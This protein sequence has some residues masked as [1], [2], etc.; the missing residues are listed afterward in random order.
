MKRALVAGA[1]AAGAAFAQA[2]PQAA[3][4]PAAAASAAA[5]AAPTESPTTITITGERLNEPRPAG[6][7]ETVIQ[8]EEIARR[9]A[10]NV[11]DVLKDVPGVGV[12]GGP[13][14]SGMKFTLRG[15]SDNEDVLFKIDGAAKGFE[16]YR[17]GG[18][19]LLEP[20]LLNAL[21]VERGPSVLSGSGALGGTIEATTK[22]AANLLRPGE[23][24]G[25]LVK[26]GGNDN[27]SELL[28]MGA[29]Y[30]RPGDFDLLAAVIRRKS[31]NIQLADGSYLP[32]SETDSRSLLAKVGWM[33]HDRFI[34]ELGYVAYETAPQRQPYD[35]TG[36]LPGVGGVVRR[37]LDDATTTLRFNWD[38]PYGFRLRGLLSRERTYLHDIHLYHDE[39]GNPE[40]TIC[41]TS[42]VIERC[43]DDWH[44]DN[45][46]AELFADTRFALGP[47]AADLTAGLQRTDKRR[48]TQRVTSNELV[49]DNNY[50]GGFNPTQ[51]PGDHVSDALVAEARLRWRDF[52][53]VPGIRFDRYSVSS[54]GLAREHMEA[55][56]QNPDIGF[57]KNQPSIGL[58][59]QPGQGA[60]AFTARYNEGFRPPL[61]DEYF[62]DG[63]DAAEIPI[64]RCRRTTGNPLRPGNIVN[65][66]TIQ[67]LYDRAGL[68][69]PYD[70]ALDHAPTSEICG[71]LYRPQ[72]SASRELILA[73]RPPAVDG[74]AWSARLTLY[75]ILT[76]HL[77]STLQWV[78]GEVGQPGEE[79]RRGIE[80]E[81]DYRSR[82]LFAALS[83][84]RVR[85]SIENAGSAT[86]LSLDVPA[87]TTVLTLGGNVPQWQANAG[88][89]VR[90]IDDRRTWTGSDTPSQCIGPIAADGS[91]EQHGV[92]VHELFAAWQINAS[93]LLRASVD[94][95]T[96]R[97]YCGVSSF[98]GAVGFRA[99]GRAAKVSVTAQF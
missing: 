85:R 96:N 12:E 25:G 76:T 47:V 86:M 10:D 90:R 42:P 60:W 48:D 68:G 20:E 30:G 46:G 69:L 26:L 29:L 87:D 43:D 15:F 27:N 36:G 41:S 71:D 37:S 53:L 19:V 50:P 31:T 64:G 67:P 54:R 21:K 63:S 44:Y 58:T 56:G 24:Y 77:L 5:P 89:R 74:H 83:Y 13:R 66:N 93:L 52:T 18:G 39:Q 62:A 23:Q 98:S 80:F 33:P 92:V 57:S 59:W 99:A 97:D 9:Q 17:F 1:W 78:D 51:P 8:R 75:R 49:N 6:R 94:N 72:E 61:I 81:G 2:A 38:S 70:P 35:A 32:H 95:L 91:A 82:W 73:W 4:A 79:H 28:G 65:E 11:F 3:E 40:S 7:P 45:R 88:W 84:S 55:A 14:A 16:K 34:A 22:S